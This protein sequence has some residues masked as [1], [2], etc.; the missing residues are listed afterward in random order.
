MAWNRL[1]LT[2]LPKQ[3][4]LYLLTGLRFSDIAYIL[5]LQFS[6]NVLITLPTPTKMDHNI[7]NLS[8]QELL[9]W[10]TSLQG[11]DIFYQQTTTYS[12]TVSVLLTVLYV[13]LFIVSL[14]GNVSALAV[15]VRT[16]FKRYV[17]KTAFLINLVIADL[18]GKYRTHNIP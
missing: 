4:P 8:E 3:I 6:K 12:F 1:T 10:N 17:M 5:P 15:L 2:W 18:A 7:G 13:P 16:V 11:L 14:L 9:L